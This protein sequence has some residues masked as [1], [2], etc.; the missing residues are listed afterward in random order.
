MTG[1]AVDGTGTAPEDGTGAGGERRRLLLAGRQGAV[2]RSRAFTREVLEEWG[3]LPAGAPDGQAAEPGR[4]LAGEDVLLMTSELV[5]NACLHAEGPYELELRRSGPV[6]RVE[7]VDRTERPPVLRTGPAAAPGG[8]G[9]RVVDRLAVAWGSE[10][11][12]AGKAVWLET[13]RPVR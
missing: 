1:E 11:R 9:L 12:G 13:V 10:A 3:W 5:T 6:L 7:V 8:H 2:A 4:W